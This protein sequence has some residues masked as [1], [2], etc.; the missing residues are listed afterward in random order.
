MPFTALPELLKTKLKELEALINKHVE[1]GGPVSIS[2]FVYFLDELIF[3][4]T[5]AKCSTCIEWSDHCDT[6]QFT[7]MKYSLLPFSTVSDGCN[8][9]YRL[10]EQSDLEKREWCNE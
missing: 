9:Q 1:Q 6:V 2:C 8:K 4:L 3:S 5:F 10:H 7:A